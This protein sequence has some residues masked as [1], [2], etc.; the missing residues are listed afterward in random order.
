MT[1]QERETYCKDCTR[2]I[3]GEHPDCDI[4][5]ENNGKYVMAGEKCFCKVDEKGMV[6]RY[7]W[8]SEEEHKRRRGEL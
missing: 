6:E 8:I 5:I 7:P 3:W 2:S 4:N 1:E